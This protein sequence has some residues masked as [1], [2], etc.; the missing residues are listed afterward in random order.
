V[1][2]VSGRFE[3]EAKE[4]MHAAGIAFSRQWPDRQ[5]QSLPPRWIIVVPKGFSLLQ[6]QLIRFKT[7]GIDPPPPNKKKLFGSP[8]R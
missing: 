5:F 1:R 6:S 2:D 4:G 8:S 7:A 3:S